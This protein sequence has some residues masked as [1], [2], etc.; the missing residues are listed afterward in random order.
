[1]TSEQPI[2][3]T[4]YG[5][6][7]V[8]PPHWARWREL[9]ERYPVAVHLVVPREWESGWFGQPVIARPPAVHEGRFRV[10]PLPVLN[11]RHWGRYVF[12][13]FDATLRQHPA[14][15]IIAYGEEFS[16]LL[17]QIIWCRRR[18]CPQ[19]KLAFFT[20]NN[21]AIL[22]GRRQWLKRR[23]WRRVCAGTDLAIGGSS[24]AARL[25][26]EA[27]YPGEIRV[28]TELGVDEADFCPSAEGRTQVRQTIGAEGFVLGF[29]GR[30]AEAK[31]VEDMF[32]ALAGLRVDQPWTLLLVGD[33]DLRETLTERANQLG[34]KVVF[35]GLQPVAEMPDWFRA[36]DCLVLPSRTMPDWKEQF[37]LVIPQAMLCGVPVLGSDSGAIPEVVGHLEAVFPERN[38]AALRALLQRIIQD[39]SWRED[40]AASQRRFA[41]RFGTTSL[42]AETY[43]WLTYGPL[44]QS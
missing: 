42:A 22:G 28:Q 30:L 7:L 33:G 17:Q 37:G 15:A 36:M 20:W 27:N 10:S 18:C 44:A 2:R 24:E 43:S 8:Q 12:R 31:G 25:L 13:S 35:A 11:R 19:A 16:L 32:D 29:A 1:V 21:L 6:A 14:D 3:L 26:R 23:F 5:H 41:R 4:V 34:G 40:L 9:A 38:P 39:A